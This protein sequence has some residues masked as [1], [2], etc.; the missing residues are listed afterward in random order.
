MKAVWNNTV[1]AESDD[2]VEIEGSVYFPEPS[3]RR[4]LLKTG[5]RTS[6]CPW[7][8]TARYYSIVVDGEINPDAAWSYADPKAYASAIEGHIAF[9]RGVKISD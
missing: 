3:V 7:K 5:E 6:Y 9:W 4:D 2:T 1:I 8:G